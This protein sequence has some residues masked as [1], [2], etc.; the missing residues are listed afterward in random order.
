MT[1]L[2]AALFVFP[3]ALAA[4]CSSGPK[5]GPDSGAPAWVGQPARTVD[6]GYIVYVGTG[7]DRTPERAR[8]KAEGMAE[9]DLANECS[10]VPK[11]ARIEDHYDTTAEGQHKS[12]AK[13][14]I[15][16]RDCEQAKGAL[17]PAEIR[18]VAN[19]AMTEQVKKY[20][21]M[22]GE[23]EEDL[24]QND[25][26]DVNP[27]V[28]DTKTPSSPRPIQNPSQFFFVRQ[29]VA[30][31][32]QVVILSPPSTYAPGTPQYTQ[33]VSHVTPASS[34]VQQYEAANPGIKN[35]PRTWSATPRRLNLAR[36]PHN[37]RPTGPRGG[38]RQPR[39]A[40]MHMGKRPRRGRGNRNWN[41]SQ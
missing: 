8:F 40:A 26:E 31:Q 17:D 39:P 28:A 11:G 22:I 29:V 24:A 35:W 13:L 10:F 3:L 19:V 33:F 9:Q 41:S 27:A 36:Q 25:N 16:F 6:N 21:E 15:E 20:Q 4:G 34:Q 23:N 18:K 5:T 32:K 37:A 2:K 14:A 7:E 1:R 38:I 30:Y 12:Y